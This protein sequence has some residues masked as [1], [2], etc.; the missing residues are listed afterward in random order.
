M[1]KKPVPKK[2]KVTVT[3][4]DVSPYEL[5]GPLKRLKE[6]I[7][8]WIKDHG[9]DAYLDWDPHHYESYD[10]NPS[11]R[12]NLK[13]DRDETEDEYDDRVEKERKHASMI[14]ER[15]RQELERL[16]QKYGKVK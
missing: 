6:Q 16:Q 11:P 3:L 2:R 7:E 8:Q 4:T 15:E 13:M 10:P 9:E 12:F 1:A 5:E 14:E